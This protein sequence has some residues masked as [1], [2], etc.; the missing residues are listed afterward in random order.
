MNARLLDF[1]AHCNSSSSLPPRPSASARCD[2]E[3]TKSPTPPEI[4]ATTWYNK[5]VLEG[6]RP[7]YPIQLDVISKNPQDYRDLLLPWQDHPNNE[8]P[9]WQV[10]W[11]QW[12]SWRGFRRWQVQNRTAGYPHYPDPDGP[13][14]FDTFATEFRRGSTDYQAG[15]DRLFARYNVTQ[16]YQIRQDPEQQ[17]KMT[18]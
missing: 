12:A 10:F 17:D 14:A 8:V 16:P 9:R 2:D 4:R 1:A 6:G 18:T 7:L 15:L 5:L 13:T 3:S 11:D